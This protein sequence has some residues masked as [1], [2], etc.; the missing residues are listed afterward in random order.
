MSDSWAGTRKS[1]RRLGIAWNEADQD[2][3]Y[4]ISFWIIGLS[5]M[6]VA[7]I[8]QFGAA[9]TLFCVGLVIWKAGCVGLESGK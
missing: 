6:A 2:T 4:D 5:L 9:G 8:Y 1:L 3:K 7:I